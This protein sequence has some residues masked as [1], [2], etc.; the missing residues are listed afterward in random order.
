MAQPNQL[1]PNIDRI[2]FRTGSSVITG[3]AGTTHDTIVADV[4]T[5]IT[6]S[7]YMSHAGTVWFMQGVTWT[8]LTIN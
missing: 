8:Q 4:G 6:G 1:N 7:M 3:G 2:S 5:L